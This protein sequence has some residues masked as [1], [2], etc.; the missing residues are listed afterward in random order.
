MGIYRTMKAREGRKIKRCPECEGTLKAVDE[1]EK[2]LTYSC[3]KCKAAVVI[4]KEGIKMTRKEKEKG[5]TK[6]LVP[7]VK[8]RDRS[9]EIKSD[10]EK[11]TSSETNNLED[12]IKQAI[13]NKRIIEILY[14]DRK[15]AETRRTVEPY[16]IRTT[17]NGSLSLYAYCLKSEGIRQFILDSIKGHMLTEQQF[18]SRF[19]VKQ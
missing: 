1:S 17:K 10:S 18:E 7:G 2:E 11:N 12:I 9:K 6:T 5:K 16:E 13:E 3:L 14:I 4:L 15:G 8:L 19:E